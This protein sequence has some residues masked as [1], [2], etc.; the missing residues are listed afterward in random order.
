MGEGGCLIETIELRTETG[1]LVSSVIYVFEDVTLCGKY[2][3][4]R[5]FEGHVFALRLIAASQK[6]RTF[7]KTALRSWKLRN[8]LQFQYICIMYI[9]IYL[10]I[11]TCMKMSEITLSGMC[12]R[13]CARA[14]V[15]VCGE[16]IL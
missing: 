4:S 7:T 6:S 5:C 12:V 3:G 10:S 16:A 1:T 9:F 11:Q 15:Y 2:Q 13:A 8:I 14:C